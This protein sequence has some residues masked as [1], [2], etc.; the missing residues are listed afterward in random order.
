MIGFFFYFLV[1]R[2][3]SGKRYDF[4]I[5]S[6][7]KIIQGFYRG[8]RGRVRGMS[9]QNVWVELEVQMKVIIGKFV[10]NVFSIIYVIVCFFSLCLICNYF[11]S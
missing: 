3:Y 7:V 11:C 6:N 1:D 5:G 10:K 2:V 9:G 4:L 8:Y